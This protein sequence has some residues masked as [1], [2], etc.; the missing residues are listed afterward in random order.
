MMHLRLS[1]VDQYIQPGDWIVVRDGRGYTTFFGRTTSVQEALTVG[2]EGGVV[3]TPIQVQV[4]SWLDFLSRVELFSP[5]GSLTR[6]VGTLFSLSDWGSIMASAVGEYSSGLLGEALA[7]LFPKIARVRLPATL[8]G[9]W[10]GDMVEVV[11]DDATAGLYAPEIIVDPLPPGGGFPQ[12]L[13]MKSVRSSAYGLLRATFVPEPK[14]IE[15]FP[16]LS[17]GDVQG[18]LRT[19]S[20]ETGALSSSVQSDV[21]GAGSSSLV[22]IERATAPPSTLASYLR[23]RPVLVYRIRPWRQ[24]PLSQSMFSIVNESRR[25]QSIDIQASQT[26]A[27]GAALTEDEMEAAARVAIGQVFDRVTWSPQTLVHI[28]SEIV[29]SIQTARTDSSRL[30]C[31][32][33]VLTGKDSL[34]AVED[35]GL[36]VKDSS[37]IE[38]HGLRT[39]SPTWPLKIPNGFEGSWVQYMRAVCVQIL[40]FHHKDHKLSSGNMH[41]A[42]TRAMTNNKFPRS[43][44]SAGRPFIT[45]VPRLGTVFSGYAKKVVHSVNVTKDSGAI[46]ANTMVVFDRGQYGYDEEDTR[47]ASLSLNPETT[48]TGET[49]YAAEPP[50]EPVGPPMQVGYPDGRS[51]A[52]G[53]WTNAPIP[54]LQPPLWLIEWGTNTVGWEGGASPLGLKSRMRTILDGTATNIQPVEPHNAR[55]MAAAMYVIYRYWRQIHPACS[56]HIAGP[57]G[58][59]RNSSDTSHGLSA[60]VD[61]FVKTGN[62][63]ERIAAH[64]TWGALWKLA[65]AGRI[66]L[67]G[68]GL[69]LNVN[70]TTGWQATSASSYTPGSASTGVGAYAGPGGSAGVHYDLRGAFGVFGPNGSGANSWLA[71]DWTGDGRDEVELGASYSGGGRTVQATTGLVLA[72]I[73][74]VAGKLVSSG[75]SIASSSVAEMLA[76]PRAGFDE[77][78]RT[79]VRDAIKQYVFR[80]R[81]NDASLPEVTP[82]V[83]NVLQVLGIEPWYEYSSIQEPM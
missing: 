28:P 55:V 63:S 80:T 4:E 50:P 16:Y 15:L 39:S 14:L 46:S 36:P 48:P 30:N 19:M 35:A 81:G 64:R 34:V 18:D 2:E 26:L 1:E 58:W 51:V 66:P 6:S 60:G 20:Q 79:Q 70:P 76:G 8:G 31:V 78:S 37:D 59:K 61:F 52:G 71:T 12:N 53:K 49:T 67:G 9:G 33:T 29:H 7:R 83:P 54:E 40:Q 62:G 82:A 75:L 23:S 43:A 32:Y 69:Y 47:D 77:S 65:R 41:L 44:L 22:E 13:S 56:I 45:D 5:G 42:H 68:K 21:V 11:H 57:N 27:P 3:L 25:Y 10:L 38:R 74:D 72:N 24:K 73:S 17:M